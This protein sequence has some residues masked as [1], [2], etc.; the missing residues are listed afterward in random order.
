MPISFA[1]LL[2][3]V[4]ASNAADKETLWGF[5]QRYAKGASPDTAPKLDE[6]VGYAL[7][8]FEDFVKPTKTFRARQA[9]WNAQP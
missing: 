6:L 4:S 3:L 9:I 8:Y 5:I 7:S 2:N 1:L